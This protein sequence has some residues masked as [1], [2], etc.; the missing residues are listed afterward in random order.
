VFS[1]NNNVGVLQALAALN[2]AS[3]QLAATETRVSTGLAVATPKDDGA[4]FA[5]AQNMR[6]EAGGWQAVAQNIS[7]A[8]AITD[9][10]A[11]GASRISDLLQQIEAQAVRLNDQTLDASSKATVLA[12]IKQL[13][14]GI[15][16]SAQSASFGGVDLLVPVNDT[17]IPLAAPGAGPYP[18]LNFSTP[19]AGPPGLIEADF[20]LQNVSGSP[21]PTLSVTGVQGNPSFTL[22]GSNTPGGAVIQW[23][24]LPYGDWT[25]FSAQNPATVS[26]NLHTTRYPAPSPAA[27]GASVLSL[28]L[29]PFRQSET[30]TIAPDGSTDDLY[31]RP[32]TSQWL[33]FSNIDLMSPGQI[34]STVSAAMT[35]VNA[36]AERI[37][38]Q[39]NM[40]A[41]QLAQANN[42]QDVITTGVGNLVDANLAKESATLQADQVRQKL[43]LMALSIA[44]AAPQALLGLFR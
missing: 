3:S 34:L 22:Q 26:F 14:Q 10:A 11:T 9:V 42:M 36:N 23:G 21:P 38:V 35:Q 13:V 32:M 20:L 44:N 29:V 41:T 18:N 43:A 7:R 5:I 8:Q 15:D 17:A 33:G 12:T 40:L 6:S 28:A 39:Q 25:D 27:Y 31:Y 24:D 4:T 16:L 19:V 2:S 37:G 1:V 30:V